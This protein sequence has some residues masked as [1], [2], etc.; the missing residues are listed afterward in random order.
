MLRL[1]FFTIISSLSFA[2]PC[3]KG[4]PEFT[5]MVHGGAGN[6][7]LSPSQKK[8]Y[9]AFMKGILKKGRSQLKGGVSSMDVVQEMVRLME[10]SP[11]FNAGKGAVKN[12]KGEFELDASIMDGKTLKAGAV[13]ALAGTSKTWLKEGSSLQLNSTFGVANTCQSSLIGSWY[14]SWPSILPPGSEK[15][16]ILASGLS[17]FCILRASQPS[18]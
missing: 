16:K 15:L 14:F 17:A 6:W 2:A 9:F 13:A 8:S 7:N 5:L 4:H 3:E 11:K 12:A 1:L 18:L 10:D